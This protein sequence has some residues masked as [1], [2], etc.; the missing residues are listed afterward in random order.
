MDLKDLVRQTI[1]TTDHVCMMYLG[2][3]TDADLLHRPVEGANHINW[4]LGHLIS[5]EHMLGEMVQSGAMP[6]LP[7]GFSGK[8]GSESA[9]GDD[10]TK[11]ATKDEL[12]AAKSTQR[13][14]LL[15]LL[16]T[17]PMEKL[18]DTAPESMRSFFPNMAALI[19]SA[20]SHWM[21]HAGQWAIVR[22]SLGKPAIF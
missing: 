8:Y 16:D 22:R 15:N 17:L 1:A 20:D 14:G 21:M 11:F 4:Q 7:D 12:L 3:L 19:L 6:A 10:A 2:D 9:S 18:S 13:E 5:S